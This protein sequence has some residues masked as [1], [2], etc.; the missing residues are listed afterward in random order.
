TFTTPTDWQQ[1]NMST[2][3]GAAELDD[4][5]IGATF[6]GRYVYF[7]PYSSDTFLRCLGLESGGG[8][9]KEGSV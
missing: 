2:A 5:Y 1:M 4:A 8:Y 7:V 9:G 3:Q 6:D